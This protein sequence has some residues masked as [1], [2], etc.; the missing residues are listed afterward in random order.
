MKRSAGRRLALKMSRSSLEREAWADSAS[1]SLRRLAQASW[2]STSTKRDLTW[3]PLRR[4]LNP[5]CAVDRCKESEVR[6]SQFRQKLWA[7]RDWV[8]DFRDERHARGSGH[9]I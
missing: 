8:E 2:L 6:G 4:G 7:Q 5:E 1:K 9:G 3:W